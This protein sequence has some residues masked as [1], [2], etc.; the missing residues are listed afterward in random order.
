MRF[1]SGGSW[2]VTGE[3]DVDGHE[4]KIV[5]AE[6]PAHPAADVGEGLGRRRSRV[7]ADID[8]QLAIAETAGGPDHVLVFLGG[9]LGDPLDRARPH[10][11]R[12]PIV[13]REAELAA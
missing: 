1:P 12:A 6:L 8:V 11:S 10:D 2:F 3:G 4:R 9:D 5:S 13:D 7:D